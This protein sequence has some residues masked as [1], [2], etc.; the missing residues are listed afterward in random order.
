MNETVDI[1]TLRKPRKL[2]EHLQVSQDYSRSISVLNR[3]YGRPEKLKSLAK[4]RVEL[5]NRGALTPTKQLGDISNPN[6][7]NSR[8][9]TKRKTWNILKN[10]VEFISVFL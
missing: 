6:S 10:T 8:Q 7:F 1:E 5:L 3:N 2:A 4:Q 9:Q